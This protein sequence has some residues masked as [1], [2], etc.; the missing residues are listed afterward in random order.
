MTIRGAMTYNRY[1]VRRN[2]TEPGFSFEARNDQVSQTLLIPG[3]DRLNPNKLFAQGQPGGWADP[4]DLTRM[5]QDDAGT[6]PMTLANLGTGVGRCITK[7]NAITLTQANAADRPVWGRHPVSGIRNQIVFSEDASNAAWTFFN[8]SGSATRV[9]NDITFGA[10]AIDRITTSP[11]VMSANTQ[12]TASFTLS[13][14]GQVRP[15]LIDGA[16]FTQS[17]GNVILTSTPTRY[18]ATFNL[19]NGGNARCAVYNDSTGSPAS[20]TIHNCQFE[21]G[22]TATPYQRVTNRF[23]ITEVGSPSLYYFSF[24]GVNQSWASNATVN[25]STTD[26]VTVWAGLRKLSDAAA[27]CVAELTAS[28][29]AN[30]GAFYLFSPISAA[31]NI[32]FASKGTTARTATPTGLTSPIDM[33]L[34]AEGDI[35]NDICRLIVNGTTVTETADQG[36]G[37]YSNATLHVGRRNGSTFPLN[38]LVYDLIIAGGAYDTRTRQRFSDWLL[39]PRRLITA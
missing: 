27:G 34:S 18:T 33:R 38:N 21:F 25:F 4:Y 5:W 3:L 36:S 28:L 9:G 39:K 7:G 15:F 2:T 26:K 35:G 30:N 12:M 29:T 22:P 11:V 20:F 6:T 8:V 31:A 1:R 16:G 17:P 13:G 14:S 23:D 37:N 10:S 32:Q 24:N 19:V